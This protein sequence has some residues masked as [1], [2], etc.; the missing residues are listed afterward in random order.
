MKIEK[1]PS[2]ELKTTIDQLIAT[3]PGVGQE[4]FVICLF[5]FGGIDSHNMLIPTPGNLNF[6]IY[7]QARRPGVR[8][9][10]SELLPLNGQTWGLHPNLGHL[11]ERWN[12]GRLAIVR[13]MGTLNEP[14]TKAQYLDAA[15]AGRFRP[16]SVGAHDKQQWLWQDGLQHRP[17]SR[18]TGWFGRL[19]ALLAGTWNL[20]P[21]N[22]LFSLFRTGSRQN[23]TYPP[24]S[25]VTIPA[26]V[27]PG[28]RAYGFN[29]TAV[30]QLR[31]L[32]T[33]SEG[34]GLGARAS[35]NVVRDAFV[36]GQVAGLAAP[37]YINGQ[38]VSLPPPVNDAT[39]SAQFVRPALQAIWTAVNRS[40]LG[41]RAGVGFIGTGGW[42]NHAQLRENQDPRLGGLNNAFAALTAGIEAMGLSDRV[43]VMTESEFSRTLVDNANL[44]TDH[45][46]ASHSF[47]FGG[48]VLGGM[49]GPE[50]DYTL[51][52]DWEVNISAG[53]NQ[54][55]IYLPRIA[56][57][58]YYASFLRW[59]GVPAQL[60]PLVLPAAPRFSPVS[61]G[62]LP[63]R[64]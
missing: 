24:L 31:E 43:T 16:L 12:A 20:E 34:V 14:T 1:P 51:A 39:S 21:N 13:E 27:R 30:R 9:E 17:Q 61:L 64:N 50:P 19:M 5:Q 49:Y 56:T 6:S 36:A 18:D 10:Q 33:E 15:Q 7:E 53:Q 41:V 26:P 60:I 28:A 59:L 8:I 38:L 58:Q 40:E 32:S 57:E 52:G 29:Q 4:R 42:D 37:G 54:R 55:G 3:R 47:V 44:G 62:F 48:A 22:V 23:R 11:A 45:G 46:W 63:T 25:P 35:G 2:Y